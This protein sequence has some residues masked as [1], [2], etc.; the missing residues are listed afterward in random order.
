MLAQYGWNC[1]AAAWSLPTMQAD[2]TILLFC[3]IKFITNRDKTKMDIWLIPLAQLLLEL[4][5]YWTACMVGSASQ[6]ECP[7]M[8]LPVN[9][10]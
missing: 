9:F 3:S 8:Q 6:R 2:L 7:T 5:P 4:I 1:E 10:H